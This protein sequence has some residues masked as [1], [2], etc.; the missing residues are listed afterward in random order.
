MH[1]ARLRGRRDRGRGARGAG[2]RPSARRARA[3][4][5]RAR[6]CS[7]SRNAARHV[8]LADELRRYVVE[9]V[10]RTR[11]RPQ[12]QLGCGPRASIALAARRQGARAVRRRGV[13]AARSTCTSSRC[14][15]SRTA[16]CSIRRRSSPAPP[17]RH[18]SPTSC[19]RCRSPREAR[20]PHV[21]RLIYRALR[22]VSALD[23]WLRRAADR[24]RAGS[25]WA[26]PAPPAPRA[27]TPTRASTYRR[28]RSSSRCWFSATSRRCSSGPRAARAARAAALRHGRGAL[29]L[30]RRRSPTGA[31]APF[32]GRDRHRALPRPAPGLRGVAARARAGRGA[33]QLVRPQRRLLPLALADRAPPAARRRGRRAAA[34]S[35]RA[36]ARNCAL[37][38]RRGGAAASSSRAS[39]IGRSRPARAGAAGSRACRCRH[40]SSRCRGATGCRDSRCPA[41]ASSS[42]AACRSPARWATRRSSS[43]LRDYRPGDPLQRVHWKSFARTGRPVVKEY[44]DE[45]FERHALVLDTGT[46]PRRGRRLRGR[47]GG[48]RVLRLHHRHARVPARPAVRRRHR[49]RTA[50]GGGVRA[51]TAGR[52]QM[53]AEH[54]LEVARRRRRRA[55]R[56]R[57]P[58]LRARCSR[59]ARSCRAAS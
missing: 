20:D 2:T 8:R 59:T 49:R 48:G 31:S 37:P 21:K 34:R 4:W 19:A 24:A 40:A 13:R 30:P 56:P 38:S 12:V 3:R 26:P 51:Y 57:S 28:S 27:S 45:F 52:G 58:S 16:W 23:H 53:Q 29:R 43:S 44:Q 46:A 55:S 42:P 1:R 36:S 33:P 6:T 11:R 47:G 54:M 15:C 7:R 5:P 41:G 17:P 39:T 10:R 25:R 14:P 18:W 50:D 22:A 32:D 9:L 35:R